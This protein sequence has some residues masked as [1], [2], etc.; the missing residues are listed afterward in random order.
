MSASCA[1]SITAV[2]S[3]TARSLVKSRLPTA[4]TGIIQPHATPTRIVGQ[5]LLEAVVGH[6]VGH[7]GVV[8]CPKEVVL[9]VATVGTGEVLREEV[10]DIGHAAAL[11][12][13]LPVDRADRSVGVEEQVVGTEVEVHE[14]ARHRLQLIEDPRP[15]GGVSGHEVGQLGLDRRRRT[16]P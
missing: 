2:H 8:V 14:R 4:S 12:D 13:R 9:V 11:A 5:Q 1:R 10:P 16:P 3:V 15:S 6:P 7:Q